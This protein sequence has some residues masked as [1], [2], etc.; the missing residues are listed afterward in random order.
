MDNPLTYFL[1]LL[2]LF[3]PGT[4]GKGQRVDLPHSLG[5]AYAGKACATREG[6]FVNFL[7]AVRQGQRVYPGQRDAD[8]PQ[9]VLEMRWSDGDNDP[10]QRDED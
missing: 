6:I 7:Q 1:L 4:A 2:F 8:W 3:Q 5:N 10:G 9:C